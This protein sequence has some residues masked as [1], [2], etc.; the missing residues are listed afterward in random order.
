MDGTEEIGE[1]LLGNF[2]N[3]KIRRIFGIVKRTSTFSNQVEHLLDRLLS[4]Q[5]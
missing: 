4:N 5:L 3:I 1:C 2:S